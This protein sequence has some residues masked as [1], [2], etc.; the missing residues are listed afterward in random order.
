MLLSIRII[1]ESLLTA[2][3]R[4]MKAKERRVV[5]SANRQILFRRI[6]VVGVWDAAKR[7]SWRLEEEE[8]VVVCVE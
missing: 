3:W 8:R 7:R 2:R 6:M 1:G 5:T 4:N